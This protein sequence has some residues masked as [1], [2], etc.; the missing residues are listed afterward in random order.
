VVLYAETKKRSAAA[1][2]ESLRM[3]RRRAAALRKGEV[4]VGFV[5]IAPT[6]IGLGIFTLWPA[7]QTFFF[8][9]T[10]WGTFGGHTWIGV[11]NYAQVMQ[12]PELLRSLANT[13]VLT[14]FAVAGIPIA[15]ALAALLNT[16]GLKGLTFY[17]VIYFL[18]V[19]TLPAAVALVWK[20]I[21]SGDYG[22]L[23]AGLSVFGIDGPNWVSD[24][25]TAIF[26]IGIIAIWGSLGYNMILFLA[27]L[28]TIPRE[29]YEA[30]SIDGASRVRTFF[31]VT[32]PLLSPTTFFVMVITVIG[33]LQ[34]FDLVYLMIGI[35]SPALPATK[36]IVYLFYEKGIIQGDGGYAAAIAFVLLAIIALL[37][38][39]QFKMQKKWVQ[40]D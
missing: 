12:D 39:I 22:L 28:Q 26:A 29:L 14:G 23:N 36:T 1:R 16:R 37:T 4:L 11:A 35:N 32:V 10:E 3:T 2:T 40:Y 34:T 25:T 21:L 17:R 24:P 30:A 18:P 15:I 7:V 19:V 13:A 8:S 38:L 9:F 20:F 31:S 5:L 33:A 27:G 6:A